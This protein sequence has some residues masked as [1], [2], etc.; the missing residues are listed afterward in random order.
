MRKLI[1]TGMA[2]AMLAIPAAASASVNV[3][4]SGT[5][6]VGKGDVQIAL[7]RINDSTLQQMASAGQIKFTGHTWLATETRWTCGNDVNSQTSKVTQATK[8]DATANTNPQ[9]KVSNGWNLTGHGSNVGGSYVKG[10]RYGAPYVG[11]CPTGGTVSFLPAV[12]TNGTIPGLYVNGIAL[13]NTPI[14]APVA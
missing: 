9:G 4:D 14:V 12:F 8:F 11:Y 7:G 13:P 5:G 10:E 1:L 2:L 6:F 3:N